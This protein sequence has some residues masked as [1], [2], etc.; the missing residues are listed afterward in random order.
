MVYADI[1]I[2]NKYLYLYKGFCDNWSIMPNKSNNVSFELN[3][4][5][6]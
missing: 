2:F 3:G 4:V 1:V 6:F 5:G